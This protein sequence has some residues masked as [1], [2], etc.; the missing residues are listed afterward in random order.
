MNRASKVNGMAAIDTIMAATLIDV[1]SYDEL[2][3]GRNGI[4]NSANS[5]SPTT[6]AN[7]F[8]LFFALAMRNEEN[9]VVPGISTIEFM[10]A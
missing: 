5:Q 8:H 2:N 9:E 1:G 10:V 3:S 4:G 6:I 7:S